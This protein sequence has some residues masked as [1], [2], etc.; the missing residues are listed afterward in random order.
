VTECRWTTCGDHAGWPELL[1]RSTRHTRW[2]LA[3][4]M[5]G[6]VQLTCTRLLATDL[7]LPIPLCRLMVESRTFTE[8]PAAVACLAPIADQYV[9]HDREQDKIDRRDGQQ[10]PQGDDWSV[11]GPRGEAADDSDSDERQ[12]QRLGKI[13]LSPEVFIAADKAACCCSLR[14]VAGCDGSRPSALT[15]DE[16]AP[17]SDSAGLIL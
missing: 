4:T 7:L 2:G 1:N 17:R 13:L 16:G 5:T 12:T 10:D 3:Q 11:I 6:L 9:R 14:E 15:A 8:V